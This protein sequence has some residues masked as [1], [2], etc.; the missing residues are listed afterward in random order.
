L[1]FVWVIFAERGTPQPLTAALPTTGATVSSLVPLLILAI[2]A[3]GIEASLSGWLTTYSHRAGLRS[4][5]GAALAASLF[6]LGCTVSR[7]IFSTRLLARIGRRST[8]QGAVWG[9]VIAVGVLV[10]APHPAV[11]L[12]VAGVAGLCL[13]P[14]YPLLLSFLLER[15]ARGWIFAAGGIGAAFFPWLT[16]LLSVHFH[17]LRFGLIAPWSAGLFMAGLYAFALQPAKLAKTAA[18][19]H[20]RI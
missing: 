16:G 5:A 20:S 2:C 17:S 8:L 14:L 9:V 19:I 7:L 15:S 11:I 6:W 10:A 18:P 4:L 12:V 1:L 13:G 3:V